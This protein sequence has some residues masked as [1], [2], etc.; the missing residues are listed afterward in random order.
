MTPSVAYLSELAHALSLP[1]DSVTPNH[2]FRLSADG[3]ET[4]GAYDRREIGNCWAVFRLRTP[5]CHYQKTSK[6]SLNIISFLGILKLNPG[7][8]GLFFH[9]TLPLDITGNSQI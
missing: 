4:S 2:G 6:S 5:H 8:M 9:Y 3:N 1:N 7:H